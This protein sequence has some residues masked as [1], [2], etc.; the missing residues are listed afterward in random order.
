MTSYARH[1]F[2]VNK[3]AIT[4]GTDFTSHCPQGAEKTVVLGC[5]RSGDQGIYL[6]DV[7]DARLQ[8]VVQV[9]GA[10][11]MLHAA[12]LRLSSSER[13][14]VDGLLEDFYEHQLT[15]QRVKDTIAA[16]RQ[17]EPTEISNEMH[18]VFATEILELTPDLEAYYKQYFT[19][20]KKVAAYTAQYE[21]EFT[22][23]Q[24]QVADYDSQL[25]SL[26]QTIESNQS[27][28]KSKR[29][30]LVQLQ[31]QMETQRAQGNYATYNAE[32]AGYNRAVNDYNRLLGETRSAIDEYNSIV[33]KRN[34]V[35]LEERELT[36][37]LSAQSL[38]SSQ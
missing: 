12:Y 32:V 30:A 1:L 14:R 19:D 4:T 7:T 22:S 33:E 3:P 16:Y 18:S 24:Q 9:T 13:K 35:A 11:E 37:A 23:R 6:Y 31:N 38:P 34:A 20:R 2:Y 27:E 26:K 28:L 10:H 25:A 17:T 36:Q 8:G 5:Y 15:D 21:G 29:A